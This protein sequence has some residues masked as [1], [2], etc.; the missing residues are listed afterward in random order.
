MPMNMI[1]NGL[2]KLAVLL[3]EGAICVNG[4]DPELLSLP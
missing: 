3:D 2:R 4:A 1:A